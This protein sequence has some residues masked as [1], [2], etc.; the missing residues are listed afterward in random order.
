MYEQDKFRTQLSWAWKKF[1]N[2]GAWI[3]HRLTLSDDLKVR[4]SVQ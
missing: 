3:L 4:S 1:D 2:L